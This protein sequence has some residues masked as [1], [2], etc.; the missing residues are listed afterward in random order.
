MSPRHGFWSRA[1]LA[2]L[3]ALSLGLSELEK[4][5][6]PK[7]VES[8]PCADV[9]GTL[10]NNGVSSVLVSQNVLIKWF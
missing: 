1:W 4:G 5:S 2:G 3:H 8:V 9:E 10:P 6:F 7:T